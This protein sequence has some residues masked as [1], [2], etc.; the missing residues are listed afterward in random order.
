MIATD[1][2]KTAFVNQPRNI[3]EQ[4]RTI[5]PI[6]KNST[7]DKQQVDEMVFGVRTG[8]RFIQYTYGSAHVLCN[9]HTDLR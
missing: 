8:V 5:A 6:E 7:K 3:R 2:R 4:K 9:A 1:E